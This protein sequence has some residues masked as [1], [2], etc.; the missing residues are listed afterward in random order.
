MSG[1]GSYCLEGQFDRE[2][3]D[4]FVVQDEIVN[5]IV[6][7]IAGS[8]GAIENTEAKSVARKNLEQIQAYD[9]V[10]RAR[11]VMHWYWTSETFRTARAALNQAIALDPSN[12]QARREL[13]W[14]AV[15]GWVF[16]LDEDSRAGTRN[17]GAGNQGSST[18]SCR[19]ARADGGRI[20]ILLHETT[21]PVRA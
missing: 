17:H 14:L 7:K 2:M 4:V 20:R 13:A 6:A 8:Y 9:L 10:L 21:R 15:V 3:A 5:R 18:R 12:A 19:R 11:D 16:Q 1:W